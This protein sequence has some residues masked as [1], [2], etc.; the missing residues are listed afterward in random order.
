MHDQSDLRHYLGIIRR[1]A[2]LVIGITVAAALA[3]LLLALS[4]P[5]KYRTTATLVYAPPT[6]SVL[7]NTTTTEDPNR[8]LSTLSVLA[9]TDPIVRAAATSANV[10]PDV[11]RTTVSVA[12]DPSADLLDITGTSRSPRVAA[13]AANAL[14]V[15]FTQSLTKMEQARV[16][17][18]IAGVRQ[19][20]DRL[21]GRSTPDIQSQIVILQNNLSAANA[22]LRTTTGA[23]QVAQPAAVPTTAFSPRPARDA[24]IGALVG[25]LLGILV[26]VGRDRLDRRL[27]SLDDVEQIY[28][29]PTLGTVPRVRAA[30]RGDRAAGLADF[31][32]NTHLAES[33][34]TIR[35]N[36]TL[37]ALGREDMRVIAVSSAVAGEGKSAATANL[38]AALAATGSKVLAVSADVRSPALHEYFS[39]ERGVGVIDVLSEES[40]LR[41]AARFAPMNGDTSARAGEVTILSNRRR[42]AD[43]AVLYQSN[44]MSKLLEQARQSYDFVLLDAPPLLQAGEASVLSQRADAVIL[45]SRLSSLTRDQAQRAIAQLRAMGIE[46]V[47]LIV[48]NQDQE[49]DAQVYG[50]APPRGDG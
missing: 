32:G 43:P 44:A 34:R 3:A 13:A 18:Y 9:T 16:T 20:I 40:T 6:S 2:L 26:A 4:Q 11:L 14:A 25:L 35:T 10:G 28:G 7:N 31:G 8:A 36:L 12:V 47:G 21:A 23:L 41:D 30:A 5:S 48:T 17:N 42:F 29:A 46:P 19:S 15:A 49:G 45:V 33:F 38:A 1:Q 24:G 37:L 50:Y 39:S 22:E 27:R